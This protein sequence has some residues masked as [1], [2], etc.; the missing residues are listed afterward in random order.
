MLLVIDQGYDYFYLIMNRGCNCGKQG[1]RRKLNSFKNKIQIFY[2][3]QCMVLNK[4]SLFFNEVELQNKGQ[5]QWVF[6]KR[7]KEKDD[8]L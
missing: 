1:V 6:K 3:I 7:C 5:F 4:G 2:V 8:F